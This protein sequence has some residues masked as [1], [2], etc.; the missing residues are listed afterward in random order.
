[1]TSLPALDLEPLERALAALM[2]GLA[3]SEAAPADEELRDACIQRFEFTF[4][5]AWKMTKR[6][7]ER[8]LP[9]PDLLDGMS[10]RELMRVAAEQGLV[11]DPARWFEHREHRNLTSHTYDARKAARVRAA[12]PAFASDAAALLAALKAREAGQE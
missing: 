9:S 12:L 3:R 2:R 7:L 6:R 11:A 4:E 8:D 1:M 5:L 10:F